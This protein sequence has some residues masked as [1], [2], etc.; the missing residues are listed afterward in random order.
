MFLAVYRHTAERELRF[1][2]KELRKDDRTPLE[3][4]LFG[5]LERYKSRYDLEDD[6]KF[7]LRTSFFPP[8][9]LNS[10]I[11]GL[12]SQSIDMI[13]ERVREVF[14][15][16]AERSLLHPDVTYRQATDAYMAVLDG[17]FVE[18]LYGDE[19]RAQQ[20]LDASWHVFWRGVKNDG[21]RRKPT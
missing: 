14:R 9:H 2:E 1:V 8:A 16:A 12:G 7:F 10:E 19:A 13:A 17:F 20:R 18:M 15:S 3:E 4:R 6:T 5:L 11:V 21:W